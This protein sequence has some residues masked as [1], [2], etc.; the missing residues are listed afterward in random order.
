MLLEIRESRFGNLL[1]RFVPGRQPVQPPSTSPAFVATRA[2]PS[3]LLTLPLILLLGCDPSTE[4]RCRAIG[5]RAHVLLRATSVPVLRSEVMAMAPL[6]IVVPT[7]VYESA[8]WAFEVLSEKVGASLLM[9]DREPVASI[10]LEYR[11]ME[12]LVFAK[13]LR[14]R[15]HEA[16]G[17]RVRG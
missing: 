13:R 12:A 8:P 9:L 10:V 14:A 17:G 16:M 1:A 4:A 7:A 11:M 6:V 15:V 3:N 2:E 5:A